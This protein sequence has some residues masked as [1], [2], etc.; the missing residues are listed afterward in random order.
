M[1]YFLQEDRTYL[2]YNYC[3]TDLADPAHLLNNLLKLREKVTREG[4]ELFQLWKPRIARSSFLQSALNLACYLILRNQDLRTIQ[5]ALMPLGLSSLSRLESRVLTNLDAVISTLGSIANV[6]VDRLPRRPTL[7]AFFKGE[8]RLHENTDDLFGPIFGDRS[9]RIMVTLPTEAAE[10]YELV[11]ELLVRG[12]N[13]ARI[14][15]AHDNALVWAAA[16]ANLRRAEL[17]TGHRCKVLMDLSGP[18]PRTVL[19]PACG[20]HLRVFKGNTIVLSKHCCEVSETSYPTIGCTIPDAIDRLKVGDGVWIDDGKIGAIAIDLDANTATLRITYAKEKGSKIRPQKGLNFPNTNLNLCALTSK[21]I[22]DLDFVVPN[23]DI[24]GYSFVQTAGDIALLQGEIAARLHPEQPLP[25]IVAKIETPLAVRNLPEIVV[26][27]AG[28]QPL[29]IMIARG[30]LAIEIGYQRLAEIQEEIL[31]ICEASHVPVIWATQV[32]EQLV[33]K[34]IPS[35]A[36]MT[37]A[38][39]AERAEC[40]MLNKGGYICDAVSFLDGVL[41]RMKGHQFKKT[42]QLRALQSWKQYFQDAHLFV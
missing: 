15:C 24:I 13:C 19:P 14:N 16:I 9:V 32:L 6:Q 37:D 36:E 34:G 39:M 22:A 18:K 28:K 33:K 4:Q 1:S 23:A 38:A 20:S 7:E 42:S 30:D 5:M 29:G 11:R 8:Q 27:A 26:Q 35:R 3:R 31:W 17:E 10:N 12:M 2:P 41:C 21:D 25:G 40:V